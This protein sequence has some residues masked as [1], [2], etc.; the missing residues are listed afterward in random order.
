MALFDLPTPL[1]DADLPGFRPALESLQGNLLK[2]HGRDR[3][4]HVLVTFTGSSGAARQFLAAMSRHATSAGEQ[5]RQA[6]RHRAGA[7]AEMFTQVL[8]SASGYAYLGADLS[9]FDPLFQNGMKQAGAR[10]AD[11]APGEWEPAFRSELHVLVVLA[12][13]DEEALEA[14]AGEIRAALDGIATVHVEKGQ[15]VKNADGN[16]IE[17][18][19]YVDGRSQP[20]FFERDLSRE[21][22]RTTWD[23]AAGPNLILVQDPLGAGGDDCGS[24][25]VF[26]KLEQNVRGFKQR[27][28]DLADALGLT[29]AGRE[30]A[31]AMAVGRFE[32]GTPVVLHDT[33]VVHQVAGRPLPIENDFAFPVDDRAGDKC[34]F[35]SHIRK[36]NPRGDTGAAVEFEKLRRIARRGITY[37]EPKGPGE[38]I[39]RLPAGGVGLLFLCCNRDLSR[40][41]EFI[42]QSWADSANF[43]QPG[44]GIDPVAGQT[45]APLPA[46]R[47]PAPYGS[48][49]RVS[50]SFHGFVTMKGGEYFFCP[51]ITYLRSL[52]Q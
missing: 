23:P 28:Q 13:D 45:R 10:L 50:F 47:W 8:L 42:Q 52:A 3:A 40:Q 37:G 19:G 26:R 27:E 33:A 32:D 43:F 14:R 18:F 31:G 41:F 17:H 38:D 11:P 35:A 1:R 36:T 49:I 46:Q 24:Y 6:E 30:L 15:V 20:L 29:G 25:V 2:S 5:L 44:T 34:P 51:S 16:V 22:S 12:H 48:S 21:P 39:S 7:P 4:A 9:G